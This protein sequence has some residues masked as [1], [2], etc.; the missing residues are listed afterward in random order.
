MLYT[1]RAVRDIRNRRYITR[2]CIWEGYMKSLIQLIILAIIFNAQ[3]LLAAGD[4]DAGKNKSTPCAACH[5]A[6]GNS[7]NPE[8]PKLAGQGAPYI[9]DQLKLFKEKVRDNALMN[10]QAVNL[11]EQDMLDIAAYYE[12]L[13][14]T[15]GAA[16]E[17][18]VE[19]GQAIYRGGI[20][21]KGVP[22]CGACHSPQGGGNPA[23][24]FPK[25]SG[26]HATYTANQLK[27]YR[28]EVRNN[29]A[30]EIMIAVTERLTDKEI[31][32]VASY[33]SGLH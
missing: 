26:Q 2:Q 17:E 11:S 16:D 19:L 9:A 32:A 27:A 23:A 22:A 6:D 29:P 31:A 20:I 28:A 24:K 25:L 8:W 5:G 12:S 15:P 21:E 3:S 14:T 18:L 4:I 1:A 30:A 33:I 7:V 10:A 13:P